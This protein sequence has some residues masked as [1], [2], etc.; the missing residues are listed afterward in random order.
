ML[1]TDKAANGYLPVYQRIAAELGPAA[2]VCEVGVQYG[3]SLEIW[4]SLFPRGDVTGV[5]ADPGSVWPAGTRRVVSSQANPE[6]PAILGGKFD[7][8]VDDASHLGELTRV[9]FSHLWPLVDS[10]GYYVVEDWYTGFPGLMAEFTKVNS[11]YQRYADNEVMV[12]VMQSFLLMLSQP[13]AEVD[14]ITY[15][16]GMAI[17]HKK[18]KEHGAVDQ[19]LWAAQRV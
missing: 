11:F 5:D 16:F 18:R 17:I 14:E 2:R 10:G 1:Q 9:T 6:L 19:Q 13:D 3:G 15:R 7:L 12:E 8:V 4:Q